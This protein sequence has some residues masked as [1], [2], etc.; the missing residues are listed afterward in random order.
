L[1]AELSVVFFLF[2]ESLGGLFF[3]LDVEFD[4]G[5]VLGTVCLYSGFR[6]GN[7]DIVYQVESY[8]WDSVV[9]RGFRWEPRTDVLDF[10][11]I[12]IIRP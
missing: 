4:Q 2:F 6:L 12:V 8:R 7:I 9:G 5:G 10:F 11:E 3:A 1:F